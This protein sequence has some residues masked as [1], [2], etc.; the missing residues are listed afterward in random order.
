MKAGSFLEQKK[1][2]LPV[3]EALDETLKDKELTVDD[4]HAGLYYG[5]SKTRRME[6]DY[7]AAHPQVSTVVNADVWEPE[8]EE[9]VAWVS[10]E[11]AQDERMVKKNL[12]HK[13]YQDSSCNI[14]TTTIEKRKSSD[15]VDP[16]EALP[17]E[18]YT[19]SRHPLPLS[20][21]SEKT[22]ISR[23][24]CHLVRLRTC[25]ILLACALTVAPQSPFFLYRHNP[26]LTTHSPLSCYLGGL[27][28]AG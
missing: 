28:N 22:S 12:T 7:R 8:E 13:L 17:L 2:L 21:V 23:L 20:V 6:L 10:E 26:E 9:A 3:L 14:A 11:D 1:A 18:A 24:R 16:N 4:E 5:F 27:K 15:D 19:S 25:G